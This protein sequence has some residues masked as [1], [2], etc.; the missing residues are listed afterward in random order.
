LQAEEPREIAQLR[1]ADHRTVGQP[2]HRAIVFLREW[3]LPKRWQRGLVRCY[4]VKGNLVAGE[5]PAHV[6]A[7]GIPAVTE[8]RNERFGRFGRDALHPAEALARQ[9]ADLQ[10]NFG[11]CRRD[12]E[13]LPCLHP[14]DARGF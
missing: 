8:H 7:G 14:H 1:P 5:E 10:G 2:Q 4:P 11:R 12:G 9:R 3:P 6:G 13:I